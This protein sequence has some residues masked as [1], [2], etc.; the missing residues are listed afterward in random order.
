MTHLDYDPLSPEVLAD[1]YPFY[2]ELRQYAPVYQL[3]AHG[4]WVVSRYADVLGVLRRPEL[5]SSAAMAAA[6]VR[7]SQFT[8]DDTDVAHEETDPDEQVSIVGADGARH[9]RLREVVNRGPG[10]SP[11]WPRACARSPGSWRG[12]CSRQG[13][14]T[15][16]PTSRCLCPC[17]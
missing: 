9:A 15:W 16:S 8:P 2:A 7:P 10:A 11:P 4:F 13:S 14:A 12:L 17:E 5:F 3:P 6:V 1:P